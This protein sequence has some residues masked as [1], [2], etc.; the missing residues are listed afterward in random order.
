MARRLRILGLR[1]AI[2]ALI[3]AA[4]QICSATRLV[5]PVF[6]GMPSQVF[7]AL[8]TTLVSQQF[9][10]DM[11]V[12]ASET[13]IGFFV[14]AAL[15]IV[16]GFVLYEVPVLH[17]AVRPLLSF[18]NSLPRLAFVPL[19]IVWFGLGELPKIV[20]A[21]SLV[22]FIMLANSLAAFSSADR[23]ILLLSQSFGCGELT[24]LRKFVLP[25]SLPTLAAGLELSVIYSLLATVST[26]LIVASTGVGVLLSYD[27]DT[28]RIDDFFAVLFV[29]GAMAAVTTQLIAVFVK[30]LLRW[31]TIEM[32][33]QNQVGQARQ[34]E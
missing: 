4:W 32:G 16:I 3:L 10:G 23:D 28:F 17:E 27:A 30:R 26:E 11:G 15:G 9:W 8:G 1:V 6:A 33:A 19:F 18:A 7:L 14:G 29:L 2:I 24:R 34:V 21:V 31:H 13:F 12:T 5:Q 25:A 20:S 22:V